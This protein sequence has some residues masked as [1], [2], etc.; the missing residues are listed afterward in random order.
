MTGVG[1]ARHEHVVVADDDVRYDARATGR[2]ACA[3]G[4]G[5]PGAA[6]ELFRPLP[7]HAR[8]DT[9]RSLINR[10]F[11]SDYPGTLGVRRSDL[12]GDRRLRRG[13][14]VREPATDPD[15]AGRRRAGAP[16][17]RPVRRS[18][19]RQ[20]RHTSSSNAS[21]RPTTTSPSRPGLRW[22]RAGSRCW[23]PRWSAGPPRCRCCWPSPRWW[24]RWA[25]AGTVAA[26]PIRRQALCGHRSG[27]SSGRSRCGSRPRSSCPGARVTA[28]SDPR[29]G[30]PTVVAASGVA[31]PTEPGRSGRPP[32]AGRHTPMTSPAPDDP[33]VPEPSTH[34]TVCPDGPLLVRGPID[35]RRWSRKPHSAAPIGDR[36]LPLRQHAQHAVVRRHP[37]TR[38]DVAHRCAGGRPRF[39]AS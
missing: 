4:S 3:A 28:G 23:S 10:A 18:G 31:D 27:P 33:V 12:L 16:R 5:R 1:A 8:W 22:R 14:A 26:A 36:A 32:G 17:R 11:G 24:P 30:H 38:P 7:W 2:G 25:G 6:A 19:G 15:G 37:Q 29:R 35:D 39:G 20:R 34:I 21:G 13:R 9:A